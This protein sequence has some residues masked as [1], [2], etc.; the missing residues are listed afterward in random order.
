[1]TRI[2]QLHVDTLILLK[3]IFGTVMKMSWIFWNFEILQKNFS[4][5][6]VMEFGHQYRGNSDKIITSLVPQRNLKFFPPASAV[7]GIKS[8]RCV[9]VAI[10]EKK[11]RF[12]EFLMAWAMKIAPI[13]FVMTYDTM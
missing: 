12:S 4:H 7:Q 13:H 3:G 6:K 1:M 9:K 2:M 11:T 8:V 10:F 5:E